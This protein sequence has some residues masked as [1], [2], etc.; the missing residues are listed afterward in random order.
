MCGRLMGGL[1]PLVWM[2]LV[3][4]IDALRSAPVA[5]AAAPALSSPPPAWRVAFW[6]FGAVG[7]VWCV[8]F[9]LWFRNRPEEKPGV[10]AAE[11]ALI[12]AGGV[13][14]Q[15]AHKNVPWSRILASRNL[16][17]LCLMYACQSYGW[18]FYI[19]YI[20]SFLEDHY[21]VSAASTLGAVYKGGPLWIGALGCVVGGLLT[22]RIL[23][24]TGNRRLSRSLL[25]VIG[26]SATVICF[27]CCPLMP[28]AFWFFLAISLAGFFTDLTMGPAWALCQDIGRRY[29]AI[30]A[31]FMNMCGG[32]GNVLANWLTGFILQQAVATHAANLGL[33]TDQLTVV[34]KTTAELSGYHL[35]FL[36]FAGM[37]VVGVICWLLV[38]ANKPMVVEEPLHVQQA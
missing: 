21:G 3:A 14:S 34:Q 28:S 20:H 1:T 17:L 6:V 13:E 24:R 23:R 31:G 25:G 4:A 22:D 30:V 18:A 11:L 5:A 38:N 33:G 12:R 35:N 36:I 7:V 37:Y 16:W 2:L 32:V 27:L 29:A 26:H 15:A 9:A 8:L 10:N 19:T